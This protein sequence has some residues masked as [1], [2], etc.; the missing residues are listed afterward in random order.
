M[1]DKVRDEG[2]SGT[3]SNPYEVFCG[4]DKLERKVFCMWFVDGFLKV[5]EYSGKGKMSLWSMLCGSL[6]LF[7][8]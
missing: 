7:R 8:L 5:S 4:E 3:I 6:A 1:E 2:G